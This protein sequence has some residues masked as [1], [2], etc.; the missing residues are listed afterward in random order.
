M[1]P[2]KLC[3]SVCVRACGQQ[4]NACVHLFLH[5]CAR[6]KS[7]TMTTPT[8]NPEY[9]RTSSVF[10]FSECSEGR[11]DNKLHLDGVGIQVTKA[12]IHR[13][14]ICSSVSNMIWKPIK[15]T[16]NDGLG[17]CHTKYERF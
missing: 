3:V 12:L 6:S 15:E 13:Y 2:L 11:Y 10:E 9:Q 17:F 7:V 4:A 14:M 1:K 5:V 8:H 16:L